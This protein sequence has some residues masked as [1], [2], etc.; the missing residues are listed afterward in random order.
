MTIFDEIFRLFVENA[1]NLIGFGM[2]KGFFYLQY[3]TE[4]G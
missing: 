4:Y 3:G 1:Q 2:E